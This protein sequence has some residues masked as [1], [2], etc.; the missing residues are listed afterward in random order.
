M[1][2]KLLMGRHKVQDAK[3]SE[4]DYSQSKKGIAYKVFKVMEGKLYPPMVKN[5]DGGDTPMGVW[6]EAESG[7][8][9]EIEGVKKVIQSKTNKQNLLERL[10][11]LDNLNEIDRKD[12]IKKIKQLCLAYRPG[13]HL[14][15]VPRG[16]QF[17]RKFSWKVVDEPSDSSLIMGNVKTYKTF[18]NSYV[19]KANIGLV[20]YVQDIDAY[21]QVVNDNAPY[22]P[23]NF[24]WAE[25]DYIADIDYQDEAMSYGYNKN[26]KFEHSKAGLP[27]VPENGSYRYRTN[28]KVDTVEWV[29]TGAIRVNRLLGDDE[30]Y[31]LL[32]GNMPERQGGN[33]TLAEMGLKEVL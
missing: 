11:N 24:V 10:A 2:L 9:I 25:C 21:L 16:K 4:K 23:Y 32:G 28:P 15:E 8:F 19:C 18:I 6:L 33:L 14:G 7:E 30:V 20:F 12:E 22:F 26:G 27:K 5:P 13:W 3:I 1:N 29:I 17:D 31:E